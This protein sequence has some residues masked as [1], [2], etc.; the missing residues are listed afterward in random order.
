MRV[1]VNWLKDYVKTALS[2]K[3][4]AEVLTRVGLEIE[5]I[6][7][8][9]APRPD[10]PSGSG[11]SDNVLAAEVTTNRPD[12]LS[13]LGVARE[14]AAA[15]GSDFKLPD[16]RLAES[17]RPASDLTH[18]EVLDPDLCPRYTARVITNVKVGPSPAWLV[19]KIQ[20]MGLRPV[21]N[22][23]DITNFVLFEC[24][25]PL[26]AFD[27]DKLA[28]HRI[29]VRR[30][31]K[32]EFITAIDGS[33]HE[34]RG[35]EL[36]IADASRPVAIAGIMGGLDTEVGDRT[37]TVLLESANFKPVHIRRTSKR[38]VLQSDSSYRF[39]RG[40]DPVGV[41]WGSRRAAALIAEICGGKVCPG[42]VDVDAEP[43]KAR[44]VPLRFARVEKVLGV[45]V[46]A[47]D[48]RRI[49][50]ALGCAVVK[51]DGQ[52]LVAR[53][54]SWRSDLAREIDLIEEIARLYGYDRIEPSPG[55]TLRMSRRDDMLL[56]SAAAAQIL[57][58]AGFDECV[59]VSFT[60]AKAAAAIAPWTTSPPV[61][62]RNP[63]DA[64]RPGLRTSLVPSLL[65]VRQLNQ[66]R[67]NR[68]V[69]LFELAHV[70]LPRGAGQLPDE[71]L[72][73]GI[74]GDV[75]FRTMKGVVETILAHF[76]LADAVV[77]AESSLPFLVEGLT[78]SLGEC[79][80]GY[81]GLPT[82]A[83]LEQYDLKSS[84]AV[85]EIDFGLLV[86]E[87]KPKANFRELPRFPEIERDLAI[88]VDD[89]VRWAD[90]RKVVEAQQVS[91][92]EST[93]FLSEFRGKQLGEGKK[94]IAFSM[95][96]RVSDRT[97]TREEA[98]DAQRRLLEALKSRL[99]AEL[100]Q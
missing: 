19:E 17:G 4:I 42:M 27:Y 33:K 40:V 84:V 31:M 99:G 35:D 54:P 21:N 22:V 70:Y 98:D 30:A 92:L 28:G 94:S 20:A 69:R 36:V 81:V 67:R 9:A 88:V 100:R 5:G 78:L 14:L 89:S 55:V 85:A 83:V 87:A 47:A 73:L 63:I 29:V 90:V 38:L 82:A 76:G 75:D 59:T 64:D 13:Y 95:V 52:G 68:D 7:R 37:T 25:Q 2:A 77:T 97:L 34:L 51:A 61:E 45:A 58:A 44:E 3:E 65:S 74:V 66:S 71:R 62:V 1:S 80:L 91:I 18:V 96:F 86:S 50:E 11:G 24:G 49:L 6:E 26:H 8:A 48:C 79:V 15:T 16:V 10:G 46:P 72:C 12:W 32:G 53:M 93:A 41:E 39:A 23:V 57:N 43:F 56:K 60:D